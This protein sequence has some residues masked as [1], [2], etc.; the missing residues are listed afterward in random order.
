VNAKAKDSEWVRQRQELE[1][2]KAVG[3]NEVL[4]VTSEGAVMEGLTSN[5]FVLS[6]AGEVETA[7]AGVLSGTVRE[8]VLQVKA[9]MIGVMAISDQCCDIVDLPWLLLRPIS[10]DQLT[11]PIAT[12]FAQSNPKQTCSYATCCVAVGCCVQLNVV[13]VCTQCR[14]AR[15]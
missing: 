13:P 7:D 5:F 9:I 4:L 10:I 12:L 15:S 14:C 3:V 6:S 1:A 2:S 8:L 11:I